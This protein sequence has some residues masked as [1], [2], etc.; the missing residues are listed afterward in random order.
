MK[1]IY[2]QITSKIVMFLV[3]LMLFSASKCEDL[4]TE[5]SMF[6]ISDCLELSG[7]FACDSVSLGEVVDFVV[8][9]RNKCDTVISFYPQMGLLAF[10]KQDSC[11]SD[12][13]FKINFNMEKRTSM[14]TLQPNET[15]RNTYR[16]NTDSSYFLQGMNELTLQYVCRV[17]YKKIAR[18][19]NLVTGSLK[20]LPI[21]L[22]LRYN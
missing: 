15:F 14:I 16:I 17:N 18:P 9:F 2:V 13:L 7:E 4:D 5:C 12:N 20:S 22:Y 19:R 10:V 1:L 11:F 6:N 21:Y 8:C 3:V